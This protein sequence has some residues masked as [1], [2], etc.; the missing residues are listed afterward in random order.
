MLFS[1]CV[2]KNIMLILRG[3]DFNFVVINFSKLFKCLDI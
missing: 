2:T 1:M 3:C